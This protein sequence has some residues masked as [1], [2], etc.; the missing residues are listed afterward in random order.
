[1]ELKWTDLLIVLGEKDFWII[2]QF[3][4]FHCHCM[5]DGKLS[6]L[7]FYASVAV[8]AFSNRAR[9]CVCVWTIIIDELMCRRHIS[10]SWLSRIQFKH[11]VRRKHQYECLAN[12]ILH[13]CNIR[14]IPLQLPYFFIYESAVVCAFVCWWYWILCIVYLADSIILLLIYG[15]DTIWFPHTHT[16]TNIYPQNRIKSS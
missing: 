2:Y 9:A 5:I 1:M 16:H 11:L 12:C 13:L 4:P 15:Y 14:Q 6:Q 8:A 10:S 7:K 3:L